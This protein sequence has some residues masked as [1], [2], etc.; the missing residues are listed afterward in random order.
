M[1]IQLPKPGEIIEPEEINPKFLLLYGPPK[2]G[3]TEIIKSL[4]DTYLLLSIDPHGSAYFRGTKQKIANL[5]ELNEAMDLIREAGCPY[6][7]VIIDTITKFSEWMETYATQMYKNS[8]VGRRYTGDNVLEL[9]KGAGYLW[10]RRAF[11]IWFDEMKTLADRIIFLAHVKDASLTTTTSDEMGNQIVVEKLGV[12]EVASEDL[13]LV[14]KLKQISCA[15]VDAIGLL[16]RKTIGVDKETKEPIRPLRVN[17]NS[18]SSILC[19]A[20]PAHLRGQDF[21]FS[22]ERIYL[23]EGDK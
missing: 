22:W 9:P 11:S 4:P 7:H 8:S 13:N 17:F 19:G 23:P 5:E 14:G 3:K 16:Y 6:K 21:E 20:R 18:G 15:E 2:V 10:L 1:P 12:D